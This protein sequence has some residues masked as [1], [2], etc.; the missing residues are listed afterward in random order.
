MKLTVKECQLISRMAN[1]VKNG[2]ITT[3]RSW[4]NAQCK[5]IGLDVD[6]Q[7]MKLASNKLISRSSNKNFWPVT[8]LI[9]RD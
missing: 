8:I 9:Y 2:N 3:H 4:F 6:K 5:D 1:R 7:I